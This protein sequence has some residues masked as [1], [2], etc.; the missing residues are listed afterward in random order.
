MELSK[1]A[2]LISETEMYSARNY[3]PLPVVISQGEG[4]WV[5]DADGQ[6]YLDMLSAYSAEPRTAIPKIVAALKEQ[7]DAP[8]LTTTFHNDKIEYFLKAL[9]NGRVCKTAA[10]SAEGG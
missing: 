7:A 5:W 10:T 9:P 4:S 2:A 6:K 3:N 1:T 8:T